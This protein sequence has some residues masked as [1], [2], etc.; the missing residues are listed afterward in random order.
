[1]H[2]HIERDVYIWAY[3]YAWTSVH[4]CV[5]FEYAT[6]KGRQGTSRDR[7]SWTSSSRRG[8]LLSLSCLLPAGDIRL[9][10]Q[11]HP[12]NSIEFVWVS[13][14]FTYYCPKARNQDNKD[15]SYETTNI[16]VSIRMIASSC[17]SDYLV[18]GFPSK[19]FTMEIIVICWTDATNIT[20][21]RTSLGRIHL[22]CWTALL[23]HRARSMY[24]SVL[25]WIQHT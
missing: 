3:V 8:G 5:V 15:L 24:W 10:T 16:W 1:M 22:L 17:M 7:F 18:R 13:F 25:E 19:V 11:T 20:H 21:A 6:G 4:L 2:T 23:R 9:Q 14:H 12:P